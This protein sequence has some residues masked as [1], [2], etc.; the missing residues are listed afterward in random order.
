MSC[1]LIMCNKMSYLNYTNYVTSIFSLSAFRS[2]HTPPSPVEKEEASASFRW[3]GRDYKW[4]VNISSCRYVCVISTIEI[5]ALQSGHYWG[6]PITDVWRTLLGTLLRFLISYLITPCLFFFQ[7]FCI[8]LF[9]V[10]CL[11]SN[12]VLQACHYHIL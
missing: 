4:T 9:T 1:Q 7:I 12:L 11:H 10:N 3:P 8:Y 5:D 2:W 6:S